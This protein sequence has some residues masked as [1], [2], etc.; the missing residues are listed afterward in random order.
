MFEFIL[1]IVTKG[2]TMSNLNVVLELIE[3]EIENEM[4]MESL[5][6]LIHQEE[7]TCSGCGSELSHTDTGDTCSDCNR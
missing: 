5:D 3:E 7:E 4:D 1:S 2:A 6:A